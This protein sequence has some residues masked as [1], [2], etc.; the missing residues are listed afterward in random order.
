MIKI[1]TRKPENFK[2]LLQFYIIG[3]YYLCMLLITCSFIIYYILNY[4]LN[5]REIYLNHSKFVVYI[6]KILISLTVTKEGLL[7]SKPLHV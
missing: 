7:K 2:R 3:E 1:A 4:K 6:T 5:Y